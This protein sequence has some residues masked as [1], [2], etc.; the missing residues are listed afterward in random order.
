MIKLNKKI[1]CLFIV[2]AMLIGFAGCN[3]D[4]AIAPA[5]DNVNLVCL[6]NSLTAGYGATI[7]GFDDATKS[8]PA[9]LQ[10]LI[11]IPV[12]NAGVSGDETG[13]GLA[14][15]ESD[16]I[17]HNPGIVII[18]L[19]ANDFSHVVPITTTKVNLDAIIDRLSKIEGCKIY[20]TKFFTEEVARDLLSNAGIT[21][22]VF[23]SIVISQYE[24][25]LKTL[26][27]EHNVEL[28]EDIWTGVWGI[29]M[30]DIAHPNAQGYEI[31]AN[32]YFNALKPYLQAH[33]WVK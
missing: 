17:A 6:G 32:H 11:S 7:P 1:S 3:D 8:Y 15:L 5:A 28:I 27:E 9:F 29:H 12:I 23:Q 33:N 21:D 14:R 10:S 2:A 19:G 24:N 20:L 16:V 22:P 18:E 30:S 13:N 25:L 26:V 31:M 4:K